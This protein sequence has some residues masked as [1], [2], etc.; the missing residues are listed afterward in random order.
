MGRNLSNSVF[1][2]THWKYLSQSWAKQTQ[3][4]P[5]LSTFWFS[6]FLMLYVVVEKGGGVLI[7]KHTSH[8]HTLKIDFRAIT[9]T[10]IV[11]L[12][13]PMFVYAHISP[14]RSIYS[15]YIIIRIIYSH[16]MPNTN[17]A[18]SFDPKCQNMRVL[19]LYQYW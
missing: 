9:T 13:V 16:H 4:S 3:Q 10:L 19:R 1:T 6:I 8:C 14:V 12:C 2:L 5:H 11:V 15:T 7:T 17:K 18:R